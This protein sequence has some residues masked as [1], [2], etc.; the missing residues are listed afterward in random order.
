MIDLHFVGSLLS[1]T[2]ENERI[3]TDE[4]KG[5]IEKDATAE[6]SIEDLFASLSLRR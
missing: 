6:S 1:P 2:T 4:I 5:V 3:I